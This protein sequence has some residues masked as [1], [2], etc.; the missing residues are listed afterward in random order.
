MTFI[1]TP[2]WSAGLWC[3]YHL[4]SILPGKENKDLR[5]ILGLICICHLGSF[6]EK[7][8]KDSETTGL[9]NWLVGERCICHPGFML[10]KKTKIQ[11]Q[12]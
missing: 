12:S 5:G 11:E 3:I 2:N 10:A 6:Q 1:M 9:V 7:E 4:G 8:N